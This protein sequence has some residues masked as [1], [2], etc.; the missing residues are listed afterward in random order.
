MVKTVYYYLWICWN[1]QKSAINIGMWDKSIYST[2]GRTVGQWQQRVHKRRPDNSPVRTVR[3]SIPC[4]N[5]LSWHKTCMIE[6][7]FCSIVY[8]CIH[9]TKTR[10]FAKFTQ[11]QKCSQKAVS[12]QQHLFGRSDGR[13]RDNWLLPYKFLRCLTV[14][15]VRS[16][17]SLRSFPHHKQ[18]LNNLMK[19]IYICSVIT[20]N[21]RLF[22]LEERGCYD[23]GTTPGRCTQGASRGSISELDFQPSILVPTPFRVLFCVIQDLT[24]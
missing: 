23:L 15:Y 12:Y 21:K 19:S 16:M 5:I 22:C 11:V 18:S 1:R 7:A 17:L 4:F 6:K 13:K 9:E 8:V 2:A 14:F 20:F 24:V 10:T 3:D